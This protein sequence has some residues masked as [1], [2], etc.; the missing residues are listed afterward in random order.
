M[1]TCLAIFALAFVVA[2]GATVAV[3]AMALRLGVVD[4][5]DHFRKVHQRAMPRLGGVAV[6]AACLVPLLVLYL[7]RHTGLAG[8]LHQHG[9]LLL[10][11]LLGAAAALGTGIADDVWGL[12]P[13]WK[14]LLQALAASIPCAA[15]VAITRLGNPFGAPL[16][17]GLLSWP[18]TLF[19]MLC[20]MNG[21]N[22]LDGLDGLASGICLFVCV[23]LFLVGVFLGQP[24]LMVLTACLS[25]AILGFLVFNFHPASI[26]LGD[27]GSLLLGY[28][29]GALSLLGAAPGRGGATQLVPIVALGLPLFDTALAV[30][31]RWS[32]KLPLSAA[33]RQHIHHALM[34]LGLS[35]R[36]V[37]LVLYGAAVVLGTAA[38]LIAIEQAEVTLLVLG[39]L[40]VVGY[41]CARLLG[42]WGP[43]DLWNR[44]ADDLSHRRRAADARMA[45]ERAVARLH[46]TGD[47]EAL[48]GASCEAIESLGFDCATLRLLDVSGAESR[49]LAWPDAGRA[50]ETWMEL[51]PDV[52]SARLRIFTTPELLGELEV[53][54]ATH[55]S[56]PLPEAPELL[57]R[58]RREMGLRI[59]ELSGRGALVEPAPAVVTPSE[60]SFAGALRSSA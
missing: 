6:F 15:G 2:L 5:P 23:T 34:A 52:W 20:C 54:K 47:I 48:W 25:G 39:S 53:S 28:M 41:V 59:A 33:D 30:L 35:H 38:L 13:R 46:A 19:W 50:P 10:G 42:G 8:Q 31:R 7:L 29:V 56:L 18:V 24:L 17:L 16:E 60:P 44:L 12:R 3:R 27:S 49:V 9:A 21:V 1:T 55:A 43:A 40:V 11:L 22:L 45:V 26:F 32:R 51:E 14:F 36:R 57:D 37:V 4:R 58:V